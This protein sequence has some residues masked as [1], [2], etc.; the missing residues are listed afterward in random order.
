[1]VLPAQQETSLPYSKISPNLQPMQLYFMGRNLLPLHSQSTIYNERNEFHRVIDP[2]NFKY[3]WP[4][5]TWYSASAAAQHTPHTY[6]SYLWYQD[7]KVFWTTHQILQYAL[8]YCRDCSSIYSSIDPSRNIM[9]LLA[10]ASRQ[11]SVKV[12]IIT[13]TQYRS[14]FLGVY[15]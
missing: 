13:K 8:E 7:R 2:T 15:K 6:F 14:M 4:H 3:I 1:M 12:L 5:K 11:N 10:G 9:I